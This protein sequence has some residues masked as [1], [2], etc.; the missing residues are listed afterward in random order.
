[1]R[2]GVGCGGGQERAVGG[3]RGEGVSNTPGGEEPKGRV[4]RVC[5]WIPFLFRPNNNRK[6]DR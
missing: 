5:G 2:G 4:V 6:I 3:R 1:M